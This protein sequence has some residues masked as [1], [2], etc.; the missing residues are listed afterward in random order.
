MTK[1]IDLD[2][3]KLSRSCHTWKGN[4]EWS[5]DQEASLLEVASY[6]AGEPWSDSPKC[7]S[8]IIAAFGRRWN[9]DLGDDDRQM[10]K[11]YAAKMLNTVGS[12]ALE[13]RRAWMVTDWMVRVYMPAWL[14]LAN[15]GEQAT[16]VRSLPALTGAA[17]WKSAEG[18]VKD[19]QSKASAAWSAAW[20]AAESAARSAAWSAA[21]SAAGSAAW[22]AAWS[23]AE[24]AARSAAW[25]AAESAAGSAAGSAAWSAAWSAAE[26]AAESAA[27]SAAWSAA[28]SAAE[29]AAWSAAWSA[30]ESAAGSAAGSAAES[31]LQP[32]VVELQSSAL[33]LLDRMI[34]AK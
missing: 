28:W 16:T 10:L 33:E 3:I 22:S 34:E 25:S 18:K 9:D 15:L 13:N 19:A 7:V 29:S 23:A 4:G 14:D 5:S 30:A 8:P 24:S 20:S 17:S 1:T 26:S 11:P 6:L 27:R 2:T 32:T 12:K 21:E 31:A